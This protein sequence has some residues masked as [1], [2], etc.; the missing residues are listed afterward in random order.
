METF[1][2]RNFSFSSFL[3]VQTLIKW[4]YFVDGPLVYIWNTKDP[5][6]V[7]L[8]RGWVYQLQVY[9]STDTGGKTILFS[10]GINSVLDS[11]LLS[12]TWRPVMLVI[13]LA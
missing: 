5:N 7:D 6:V 11:I 9:N 8:V 4:S 13:S 10:S 12:A 1:T 3:F 2:G